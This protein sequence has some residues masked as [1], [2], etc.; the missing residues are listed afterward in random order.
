MRNLPSPFMI[1]TGGSAETK[2]IIPAYQMPQFGVPSSSTTI[3]VP[4][5][6]TV[7]EWTVG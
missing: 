4:V 2:D 1:F 7:P 5:Q 3:K 6:Y